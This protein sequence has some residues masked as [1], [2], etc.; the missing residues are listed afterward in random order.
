MESSIETFLDENFDELVESL[1]SYF[2]PNLIQ[3]LELSGFYREAYDNKL[4]MKMRA[5]LMCDLGLMFNLDAEQQ[6][7]LESTQMEIIITRSIYE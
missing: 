6:M 2:E 3:R 4:K 5:R 1:K 7:L